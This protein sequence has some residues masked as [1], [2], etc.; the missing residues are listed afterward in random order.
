MTNFLAKMAQFLSIIVLGALMVVIAVDIGS[1]EY[2]ITYLLVIIQ[3]LVCLTPFFGI[4]RTKHFDIFEIIY[5]GVLYFFVLF[6]LR[7]LFIVRYGSPFMNI[8]PGATDIYYINLALFYSTLGLIFLLLGYYFPIRWPKRTV[9]LPKE[10]SSKRVSL[11]VYPLFF[12]G[13]GF[14]FLV[15][16]KMGGIRNYLTI[17]RSILLTS[18]M[19]G[20]Y[21]YSLLGNLTFMA[22]SVAF[23]YWLKEKKFKYFLLGTLPLEI[24][25][26]FTTGSKGSF[27][28]RFFTL[29]ITYHYLIKRIN[30]RKIAVLGVVILLFFPIFNL[31]R[32]KE[33]QLPRL[34]SEVVTFNRLFFNFMDRFHGIEALALAIKDTPGV[35]DFQFG[36]SFC[37]ILVAPIPRDLWPDKPIIS[38]GK[39][40]AEKYMGY[41]Y[42]GTGTAAATGS[43]ELYINFHIAGVI[44]GMFILGMIWRLLPTI[45]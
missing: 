32:F 44:I 33:L 19:M 41:V 22:I 27:F 12:V 31:Y 29:L 30:L 8:S 14:R 17:S 2:G 20:N 13:W 11:L 6:G 23:I 3:F 43:A 39:V 10:W 9:F 15:I 35:M 42:G 37:L 38:F 18:G 34:T 24:I 26:A 7:A 45:Y 28:G 25:Y 40:F 1:M 21:Y 16:N 5:F 4:F 36:K